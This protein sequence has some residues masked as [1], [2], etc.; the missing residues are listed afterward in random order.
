MMINRCI[1]I[2]DHHHHQ[3][4]HDYH[5]H[6]HHHHHSYSPPNHHPIHTYISSDWRDTKWDYGRN[7][8]HSLNDSLIIRSIALRHLQH[9]ALSSL[10][11]WSP[12]S[13]LQQ[14]FPLIYFWHRYEIEATCKIIGGS[15]YQY[16]LHTQYDDDDDNDDDDADSRSSSSRN[17]NNLKVLQPVAAELQYDAIQMVSHVVVKYFNYHHHSTSSA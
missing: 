10:S 14:L 7:P 17:K 13:R 5:Y 3:C 15:L 2:W 8:I 1:I 11:S 9:H 6:H 4:D 16:S 12:I